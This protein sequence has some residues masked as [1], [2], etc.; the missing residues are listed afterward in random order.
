MSVP[1]V[2]LWRG[3]S[4]TESTMRYLKPARDPLMREK[5]TRFLRNTLLIVTCLHGSNE[6]RRLSLPTLSD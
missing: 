5:V 4:D 3:H 2:K 6:P 1:T